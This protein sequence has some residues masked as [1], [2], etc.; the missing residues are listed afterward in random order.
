MENLEC[1][2]LNS[3]SP[4]Y[5]PVLIGN[6]EIVTTIGHTGYHTSQSAHFDTQV[7]VW[8]G[9]RYRFQGYTF[10]FIRFGRVT[11]EIKVNGTVSEPYKWEQR[12]V[13]EEGV[14]KSYLL[15]QYI[16]ERTE[17]FVSVREN[18]IY[19]NTE[20][21][22]ISA[23]KVDVEFEICYTLGD[24]RGELPKGCNVTAQLR[25][26]GA[27]IYFAVENYISCVELRGNE[28]VK[29]YNENNKSV[30]KYEKT[31][32]PKETLQASIVI[33]F[34]DRSKYYQPHA[35]C[36][37][38][39]SSALHKQY[40]REFM[41]SSKLEIGIPEIKILRENCLYTLRCNS[42]PWS[43]PPG[44]LAPHWE[45]RTF[46]DELYPFLGLISSGYVGLAKKIPYFR[47]HT[48]DVA[49][50]NSCGKGA[51]YPWESLETG[52]EGGPYGHWMDEHFHIG[53]IAETA[54]QYYLYTKD[55]EVLQEFYPLFKECANYFLLNM[56]S[57]KGG[58]VII[59][60]C[61]DYD[62]AI[63]PVENGLYTACAAIRS[64]E[65][66]SLAA[67][68][69]GINT[70]YV[71]M[72]N[73]TSFKLRQNLPT[74]PNKERYLTCDNANHRHIAEVGPIFPFRIDT[75]S[76]LAKRTLFNFMKECKSDIGWKP[77]SLKNYESSRW[78]WI[79]SHIAAALAIIKEGD[80]ALDVLTE[81][82][83]TAGPGYMPIEQIIENKNICCPWFTTA[84][85]AFL[86]AVNALFVQIDEEG[87]ILFPSALRK[88]E[89]FSF[90]KLQGSGGV[91]ISA[92]VENGVLRKLVL[93]SEKDFDRWQLRIHKFYAD[94]NFLKW[95]KIKEIGEEDTYYKVGIEVLRGDNVWER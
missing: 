51:R 39:K 32:L 58:K 4:L 71:D 46:H 13:P 84:A 41:G 1:T 91:K 2:V 65:I 68:K 15:H 92:F 57:E 95:N 87:T 42:T 86:Y 9:R 27:T 85:G 21:E 64:M 23:N 33:G 52:E 30:L 93:S 25:E 62:E 73:D 70:K 7:I 66:A 53:Q 61:T 94:D 43:I 5:I 34:G 45:G 69:L 40:W 59:R 29:V 78:M 47:L 3:E 37:F 8:A 76:E 36:E 49:V 24:V 14:V 82:C 77:G 22:N 89:K 16:C 81:T 56:V 75:K 17:S 67:K 54:W 50:K 38:S 12:L 11:R 60:S 26:H 63:S 88:I 28:G 80:L 74:T 48:L 90:S 19:I 18:G 83:K 6:G 55:E 79:G 35:V 20:I 10:P 44:V 72:W 31:L